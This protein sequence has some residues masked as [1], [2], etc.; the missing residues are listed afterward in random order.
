VRSTLK[1][2]CQHKGEK[3]NQSKRMKMMAL[4]QCG[5]DWCGTTNK[6]IKA[7]KRKKLLEKKLRRESQ[8]R[9][10]RGL[11]IC[12]VCKFFINHQNSLT[13]RKVGYKY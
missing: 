8:E 4:S 9:E 2:A 11:K 5:I 13:F 1:H 6:R 12:K 10:E 3:N 7:E